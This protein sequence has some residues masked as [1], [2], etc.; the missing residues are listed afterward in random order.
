M[1]AGKDTATTTVAAETVQSIEIANNALQ[2]SA[3]APLTIKFTNQYG[4]E[5][6]ISASDAK[7]TI[8]AFDT[9]ANA[10]INQVV[11]KFQLNA[12]GATL[13]D[14]VVVTVMYG[15][16]KATKTL[17]VVNTA[18]VS[19]VTLGAA[20]LPTGKTMFTPTGTKNVEVTYTAKNTLNEDCKLVTGDVGNGVI[21]KSSDETILPAANV[22]VDA[23]NKIIISAF[24]KAGTVKLTALCPASG[25]SSNI[26]ITINEDTSA[27]YSITLEK[28]SASFA[29]GAITP[30]Y[31]KATVADKYGTAIAT[32]DLNAADYTVTADNSQVVG[33]T[34]IFTADAGYEDC[35]KITPAASAVMGASSVVTITVNASG[36]KAQVTV[37]ANDAATPTTID[38]KK[39]TTV[40]N[41][42][43]VGATQT[44]QFDCKDQYG[45]A[46]VDSASWS[47]HYVT[48]DNTVVSLNKTDDA[49]ITTVSV[50]A[51]ALKEGT[52]TVKAQLMKDGVAV[53]EKAYTFTVA[54]NDSGT[55]TYSIGDIPTL[56][57][58]AGAAAVDAAAVD[59]G[60]A[61]EIKVTATDASGNTYTVP[62]SS[63]V[64]VATDN[65]QVVTGLVNGKY[66]IDTNNVVVA[67]KDVTAKLTVIVNAADTVKTLSKDVTIS[68]D[69]S[70]AVS[71]TFK[72]VTPSVTNAKA[73][74]TKD[75]EE[76][77]VANAAGYNNADQSGAQDV[78]VWVTDQFGGY[79]L[80]GT[81]T[82]LLAPMDGVTGMATDTVAVAGG[83]VSVTEVGGD[84]TFTKDSAK[85]RVIASSGAYSDYITV[86]VTD[87]VLPTVATAIT[88]QIAHGDSAKVTFSEALSAAG[89]TAVE[90]AIDAAKVSGT[91]TFTWNAANTE[92][93]VANTDGA[94]DTAFAADVTANLTDVAGNVNNAQKVVDLP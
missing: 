67:D 43:L 9:T 51:T 20:Q 62:V 72:N 30:I 12:A 94:N 56:Y 26:D 48:T 75:V 14:Q 74:T 70:Q 37:T 83:A 23:N 22:S 31:I 8:T 10:T 34:V 80:S 32:K 64:S 84:T 21:F 66:Y 16:V 17:E 79:S 38:T 5:S 2:K 65:A 58:N 76:Y 60:Y 47:V 68:K 46:A 61:K 63:I 4:T 86:T 45:N 33:A 24:L 3:T 89:K 53:A 57:H 13:K 29:A 93:T 41:N 88:A 6:T 71:V 7:L 42:M 54:K 55:V 59:A 77:T 15:S 85:F 49:D 18:T 91:L 81:E 52:A 78:F 44:L 73:T 87:G 69:A 35:V 92:L 11:G 28:N 40:S 36:Q 39:D 1:E 82:T 50:V 90:T 19:S 27:P 25:E